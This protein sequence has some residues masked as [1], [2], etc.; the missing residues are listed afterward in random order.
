MNKPGMKLI[1]SV[2]A[3]RMGSEKIINENGQLKPMP[4]AKVTG[5]RG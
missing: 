4:P 3:E 1:L 5:F 2:M